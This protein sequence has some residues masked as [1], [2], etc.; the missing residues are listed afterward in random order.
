MI[1]INNLS[2]SFGKNAVLKDVNFSVPPGERWAI[3]GRNGVGKSTLIRCIAGL[4]SQY[5][6]SIRIKDAD[7]ASLHPRALA[8]MIAYVPQAQNRNLVYSVFDYVMMG[9]FPYQ[10]FMATATADDRKLVQEALEL[11]DTA[12]L[13]DRPINT[14]SGGE[15][16]RVFIAGAVS[17]RTDILLLDEPTTFL[18]PLHQ[19]MIHKVLERIHFEF[20][21]TILMVT[22]DI[23]AALFRNDNIL[24]LKDGTVFYG[25]S[26]S[27]LLDKTP[28]VLHEI[29]GI[30]FVKS[31]CKDSDMT[32]VL[33]DIRSVK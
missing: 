5:A 9:R 18:D 21:C 32:F 7:I 28:S 8:K 22:H 15:Q 33:P 12:L 25:E 17:Q 11:T 10:G 4:E 26:S 31:I 19:E 1:E 30:S 13:A 2:F 14:L 24:A 6:G 20:N 27:K 3:I 16:Q 23:N 29:F